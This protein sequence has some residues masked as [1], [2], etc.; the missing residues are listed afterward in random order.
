[1][2]LKKFFC[3]QIEELPAYSSTEHSHISYQAESSCNVKIGNLQ[4]LKAGSDDLL[5]N[6][7]NILDRMN[8]ECGRLCATQDCQSGHRYDTSGFL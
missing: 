1:M 6:F 7:L 8:L 4:G 5:D 3:F 2:F